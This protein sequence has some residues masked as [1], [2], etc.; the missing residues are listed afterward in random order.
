MHLTWALVCRTAGR[1]ARISVS[2]SS[3]M[4]VQMNSC[5]PLCCAAAH[6]FTARHLEEATLAA[7]LSKPSANCRSRAGAQHPPSRDRDYP[8]R[9]KQGGRDT[10]TCRAVFS[11]EAG[12][13]GK[14]NQAICWSHGAEVRNAGRAGA[15]H[16]AA[17]IAMTPGVRIPPC[18]SPRSLRRAVLA[19][20]RCD[21]GLQQLYHLPHPI[22]NLPSFPFVGATSRSLQQPLYCTFVIRQIKRLSPLTCT[23]CDLSPH[24]LDS[25]A[26]QAPPLANHI[27]GIWYLVETPHLTAE[28]CFWAIEPV[29][30][31]PGILTSPRY[32][33]AN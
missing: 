20:L 14:F 4:I 13:H 1:Y 25:T 19:A 32:R 18:D 28:S 21:G 22:L 7:C 16:S 12:R 31:R 10:S 24:H 17:A 33:R 27:L 15:L 9:A 30:A 2:A 5:L 3:P 11:A 29:N 26:Q 8:T 23:T 6:S